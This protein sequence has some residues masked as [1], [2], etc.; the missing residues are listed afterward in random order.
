MVRKI[1]IHPLCIAIILLMTILFFLLHT[2]PFLSGVFYSLTNWKGYGNWKFVGISN[3]I[4]LFK[5]SNII[6]SYLFTFKFAVSATLLV[7][8]LSLAIACGLNNVVI[9]RNFLK[10]V[11]FLPYML[12]TLIV[13]YVFR[14]FFSNLLPLA[15]NYLDIEA[16][17]VNILGTNNAWIGVL[18]VT[19]WQSLAFNI[20]IYISGLQTIDS[21]IYEAAEIDG[22]KGIM[23]F[24]KITFPMLAPFFTINMVLCGKNFLM[25]FDQIIALTNGGPGNAT[26]SIAVLIYKRGFQGQQFAYQSANSVILFLV[27]V[28]ISI[29]QLRVLEKREAKYE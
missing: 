3:Y 10:A 11:F 22:A 4:Q 20:L 9:C 15:G 7:N 6:K 25:I 19:I 24:I 2:Y 12:G 18:I 23:R 13:S 21:E 28:S 1:K 5:D 29:F 17:K 27:V 16:L 8:I 14:F 26:T